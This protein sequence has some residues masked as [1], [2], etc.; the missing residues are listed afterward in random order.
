V[1]PMAPAVGHDAIVYSDR[2]FEH[3]F[4]YRRQ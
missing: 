4:W 1:P 3:V 2:Q